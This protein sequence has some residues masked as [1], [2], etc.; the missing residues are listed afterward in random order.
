MPKAP[1]DV[2]HDFEAS[3]LGALLERT[4]GNVSQAA[5]EA[6][7]DRSHLIDLLQRHKL[8]PT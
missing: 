5:R 7:M 1:Y 3:Y 6:R 4:R 2:L 8:K